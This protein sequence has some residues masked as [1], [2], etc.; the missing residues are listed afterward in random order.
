[1]GPVEKLPLYIIEDGEILAFNDERELSI[2]TG[3]PQPEIARAMVSNTEPVFEAGGITVYEIEQDT[4]RL[5]VRSIYGG[6]KLWT[7][8][9][10]EWSSLAEYAEHIG[11]SQTHVQK[12]VKKAIDGVAIIDG[13]KVWTIDPR[14]KREP[15]PVE[16]PVKTWAR[17]LPLLRGLCTHRL[18]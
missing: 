6:K 8:D 1:M 2:Y 3:I 4:E 9:G 17:G 5:P 15:K 14:K 10:R 16:E 18:G 11:R 7:L 12:A 13:V